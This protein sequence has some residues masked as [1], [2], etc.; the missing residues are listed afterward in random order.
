[1]LLDT[2]AWVEYFQDTEKGKKIAKIIGTAETICVCPLT[3]AEISAWATKNN[4][5]PH[6]YISKINELSR[7]IY[8]EEEILVL[9]GKIHCNQ[10]KE[11][12]KIS[13][14]DAVIYSSS[15]VHGLTLL[16]CDADFAGLANVEIL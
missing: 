2:S 13:L 6:N 1:M 11:N 5:D 9:G 14:V 12:R 15:A 8:L 10:R 16:T 3:Y 4:A 7:T